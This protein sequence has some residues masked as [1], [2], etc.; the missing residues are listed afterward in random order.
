M[1]FKW[2]PSNL[3]AIDF[4]DIEITITPYQGE[5][6][7]GAS[8]NNIDPDEAKDFISDWIS[9]NLE[10][11]D[12]GIFRFRTDQPSGGQMNLTELVSE[13]GDSDLD[14]EPDIR[15]REKPEEV[16]TVELSEFNTFITQSGPSDFYAFPQ[17][18]DSIVTSARCFVVDDDLLFHENPDLTHRQIWSNEHED[19]YGY[20]KKSDSGHQNIYFRLSTNNITIERP[21]YIE[22]TDEALS[23]IARVFDY[24]GVPPG[25]QISWEISRSGSYD[26]D[27]FHLYDI[28]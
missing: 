12:I 21:S 9:D 4:D 15:S 5:P 28:L 26:F 8:I 18:S 24:I 1:T 14:I 3:Y 23:R 13:Y 6:M 7:V 25:K 16:D 20:I 19:E 27:V 10:I 22:C 11:G 2:D 17:I